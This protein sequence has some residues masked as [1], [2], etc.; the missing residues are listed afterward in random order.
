MRNASIMI[1]DIN[2]V[3]RGASEVVKVTHNGKRIG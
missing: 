1:S 3:T 2:L